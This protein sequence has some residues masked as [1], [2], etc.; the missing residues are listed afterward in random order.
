MRAIIQRAMMILSDKEGK[1]VSEG[2]AEQRRADIV[3][4]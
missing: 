2:Y 1:E 3:E 4:G